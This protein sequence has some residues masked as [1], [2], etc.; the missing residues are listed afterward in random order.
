MTEERDNDG[1]RPLERIVSLREPEPAAW[2]CECCGEANRKR[3]HFGLDDHPCAWCGTPDSVVP[4]YR[5]TEPTFARNHVD[6]DKYRFLEPRFMAANFD[7]GAEHETVLVFQWP[8]DAAVCAD[9]TLNIQR[10]YLAELF[11]RKKQANAGNQPPAHGDGRL[12]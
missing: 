2:Q 3:S 4:L 11:E 12:D 5:G 10:A 9:M 7:Y 8:K 1:R 6:A